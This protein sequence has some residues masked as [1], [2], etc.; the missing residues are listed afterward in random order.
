MLIIREHSIEQWW[1]IKIIYKIQPCL[2]LIISEHSVEQWWNIR[3]IYKL[4]PCLILI[5]S[6]HSVE[7]WWT[8]I[9]SYWILWH[10]VQKFSPKQFQIFSVVKINCINVCVS[11]NIFLHFI[12]K[13]SNID[14]I[15]HYKYDESVTTFNS[16]QMTL[17]EF[18]FTPTRVQIISEIKYKFHSYSNGKVHQLETPSN[19]VNC[20]LDKHLGF[21]TGH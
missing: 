18:L 4:Q 6:E 11:F 19:F 1:N 5:M 10:C 7:Q 15:Q 17:T 12:R 14:I 20:E 16:L 2:M 3:I 13:I 21:K 8:L 9:V